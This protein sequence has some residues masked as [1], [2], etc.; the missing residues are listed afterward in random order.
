MLINMRDK[1]FRA[2]QKAES[3]RLKMTLSTDIDN[4]P[5][6]CEDVVNIED[7]ESQIN[8]AFM[9]VLLTDISF[10]WGETMELNNTISLLDVVEDSIYK[11]FQCICAETKSESIIDILLISLY[12]TDKAVT[13]VR[14]YLQK[15]GKS[16]M[17]EM[18]QSQHFDN[19]ELNQIKQIAKLPT[20]LQTARRVCHSDSYIKVGIKRR[21]ITRDR[22]KDHYEQSIWKTPFVYWL[23][24][25]VGELQQRKNELCQEIKTNETTVDCIVQ[26]TKS[27]SRIFPRLRNSV[28]E[29]AGIAFFLLDSS[30]LTSADNDNDRTKV[31]LVDLTLERVTVALRQDQ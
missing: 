22:S 2:A 11:T 26:A 31:F 15:L 18:G 7:K 14:S 4:E 24:T 23:V 1:L 10:A 17:M 9:T 3:E 8:E 13:I 16:G 25:M 5:I 30:I 19:K 27:C 12:E 28:Y 29:H 6:H 20:V 21:R